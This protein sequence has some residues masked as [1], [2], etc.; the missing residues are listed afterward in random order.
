MAIKMSFMFI[1]Q[2]M[3]AFILNDFE[4]RC[5]INNDLVRENVAKYL[6]IMYDLLQITSCTVSY[7]QYSMYII[8][9]TW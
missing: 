4:V 8:L 6:K 7:M 9:I 3:V 1:N 2:I 5:P